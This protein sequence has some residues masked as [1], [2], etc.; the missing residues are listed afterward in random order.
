MARFWLI[1]LRESPCK[2][3]NIIF[4][5]PNCAVFDVLQNQVKKL[6]QIMGYVRVNVFLHQ[7]ESKVPKATNENWFFA[8]SVMCRQHWL[9]P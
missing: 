8:K 7:A 2:C 5:L 1:A 6:E 3:K 9:I 4:Y